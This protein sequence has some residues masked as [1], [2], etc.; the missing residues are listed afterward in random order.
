MLGGSTKSS[1]FANYKLPP[2]Q[3]GLLKVYIASER[4]SKV[5]CSRG[6][7]QG[8]PK[9]ISFQR[10][11]TQ[12]MRI[13]CRALYLEMAVSTSLDTG[14]G[15]SA[16][17]CSVTNPLARY[18]DINTRRV[19]WWDGNGSRCDR[20]IPPQVKPDASWYVRDCGAL[21]NGSQSVAGWRL[22]LTSLDW[23]RWISQCP[24][25]TME[26][27]GFLHIGERMCWSKFSGLRL[28]QLG[29]GLYTQ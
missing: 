9:T 17:P 8:S 16:G 15:R 23:R 10:D 29:I 24:L 1:S 27:S 4:W 14:T 28:V 11:F 22:H 5:K 13:L 6:T 18:D 2:N 12:P 21:G 26:I 3:I 7:W 19:P 25:R 20:D